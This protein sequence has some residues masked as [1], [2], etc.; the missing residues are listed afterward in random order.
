MEGFVIITT[1][2]FIFLKW[3]FC[4]I[5]SGRMEVC[6]F[7]CMCVSTVSLTRLL[8]FS[9]IFRVKVNQHVI[10]HLG[11]EHWIVHG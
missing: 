5:P 3:A 10:Y 7:F 9:V 4:N 2:T 8:Q 11:L 1:I 6:M